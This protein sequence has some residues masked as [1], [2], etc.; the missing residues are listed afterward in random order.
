MISEIESGIPVPKTVIKSKYPFAAL[1]VGDS[2]LIT[3][4]TLTQI[5]SY[6]SVIGK[7]LAMKFKVMEVDGGI[8]V[9]RVK[10]KEA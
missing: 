9:W 10:P 6:A 4:K 1:K 5:R 2:F 3:G 7:K 8:R